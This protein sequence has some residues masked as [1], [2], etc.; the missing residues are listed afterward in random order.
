MLGLQRTEN[1]EWYF[2]QIWGYLKEIA[3]KYVKKKRILLS[4]LI[5]QVHFVINNHY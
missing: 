5:Q 4:Q 2:P 1:L 3:L